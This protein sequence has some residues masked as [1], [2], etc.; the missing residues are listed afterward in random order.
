MIKY[1]ASHPAVTVVTPATSKSRNMA[2]NMGAAVGALPDDA[3][4]RRMAQF[5]DALPGAPTAAPPAQAPPGPAV[6]LPAAILDRYVGEYRT[7]SGASLTF[8][9]E[10]EALL[11]KPPNLEEAPLV[12]QSETRFSDPRGPVIEFQLDAGGRVTGLILEQGPQRI[13]AARVP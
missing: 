12:A 1:V 13:P 8:R 9:R 11:V 6:V 5:V 3:M 4:R 10:G 7:A 2:D